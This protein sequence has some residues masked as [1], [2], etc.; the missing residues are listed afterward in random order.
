M[1]YNIG[2][3]SDGSDFMAEDYILWMIPL[4]YEIKSGAH[5]PSTASRLE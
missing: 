3:G 4:S 2:G 5:Y 1:S